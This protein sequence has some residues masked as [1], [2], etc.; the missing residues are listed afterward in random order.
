L[1]TGK[2]FEFKRGRCQKRGN[3]SVGI[4]AG[5]TPL[6]RPSQYTIKMNLQGML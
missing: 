4:P 3:N 1:D 2:I 6:A 5:K